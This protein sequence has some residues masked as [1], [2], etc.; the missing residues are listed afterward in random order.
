MA[1]DKQTDVAWTTLEVLNWTSQRFGEA[2]MESARLEAQVLLAHALGC[3]RVQLYTGFDKPL[4]EEELA[5]IRGLIKRRLGGE[6]MA[7]LIGEQEFWSLPFW[8]DPAVLVPRHDTETVVQLVLDAIDSRGAGERAAPRR[9]VDLCTG[10]G[11]LAVTLARELPGA[12]VI[13]TDV[14]PEA[15]AVARRNAERHA[16]TDRVEVRVGDLL[17]PLAGE[18]PFDVVV[19]NPPYV[20]TGDL[21]G[22][23]AEVKREPRL[24]LDGGPDGLDLVRR[25][26][27][28]LP[29]LVAAGGLIAI[30]HGFDQG[31]AARAI[32]D[33]SGAFLPAATRADLAGRPRVTWARRAER[34]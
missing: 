2:G 31:D 10:S 22:L 18:A 15:A 32:V 4:G 27:A 12:R 3:T 34:S 9:V 11:I 5:R 19:S 33:A 1:R 30:E 23:S 24:A 8:V 13:A 16:V 17:A 25:L 7:Y 20:A 28:G 26:V 14:S 6:P 21:A 29:P